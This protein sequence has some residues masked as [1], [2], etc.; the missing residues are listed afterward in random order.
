MFS[1]CYLRA[2]SDCTLTFPLCLDQEQS[3]GRNATRL[4]KSESPSFATFSSLSFL[5]F[6]FNYYGGRSITSARLSVACNS[7]AGRTK[8]SSLK[9]SARIPTQS[10]WS[11][12]QRFSRSLR[13]SSGECLSQERHSFKMG[14]CA[15]DIRFDVCMYILIHLLGRNTC[16]RS[17]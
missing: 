11:R 2:P 8:S 7:Q 14:R 10:S 12:S 13:S 4:G 17:G 15:I 9:H 6:T 5:T 16:S 1:P 3:R